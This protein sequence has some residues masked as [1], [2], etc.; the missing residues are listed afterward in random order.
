MTK[1]FLGVLALILLFCNQLVASCEPRTDVLSGMLHCK[2]NI[3]SYPAPIHLFIPANAGS[4]YFVHFHGHNLPGYSHFDRRW[5]AYGEY[6]AASKTGAV[7]VIPESEGKCATY[8]SHFAVP[9]N[10]LTFFKAVEREIQQQTGAMPALVGLSGHSGAYR[11]LNKLA[12][13]ALKDLPPLNKVKS[14]GLF[15]ATYGATP[16]IVKLVKSRKIFLFDAFVTGS[17]ATAEELSRKL[18]N[19]LKDENVLFIPVEGKESETLLEQHFLI[20]KRG[21]L[22]EYFSKASSAEL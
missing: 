5:G 20:L 4:E 9:A 2:V 17:K 16:E 10:A 19:D 11:V 12:G 1:S 7:L 14:I 18:M 21:S 15:D 13:Y 6:L 22:E 3:E 8:D